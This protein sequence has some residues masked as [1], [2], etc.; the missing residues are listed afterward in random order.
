M[1]GFVRID[2]ALPT[3]GWEWGK[4]VTNDAAML[5]KHDLATGDGP[6]PGEHE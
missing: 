6:G 4:Y 3:I 1:L 2:T 5:I